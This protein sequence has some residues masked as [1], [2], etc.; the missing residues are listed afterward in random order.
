MQIVHK[1]FIFYADR[2][3]N[4]NISCRLFTNHLYV[5]QI[6]QQSLIFHADHSNNMY[7]AAQYGVSSS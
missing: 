4:F 2:S 3:T 7:N 6:V 5:M 1:S